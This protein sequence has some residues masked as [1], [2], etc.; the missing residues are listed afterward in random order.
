MQRN[1]KAISLRKKEDGEKKSRTGKPRHKSGKKNPS[2]Y[3]EMRRLGKDELRR[4]VGSQRA[5]GE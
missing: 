2:D 4:T 5:S 1:G 3:D